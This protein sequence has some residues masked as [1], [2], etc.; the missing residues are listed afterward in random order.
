MALCE[1]MRIAMNL[2]PAAGY[3][4]FILRTELPLCTILQGNETANSLNKINVARICV[5]LT[6]FNA[7]FNEDHKNNLFIFNI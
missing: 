2:S 1:L 7:A 6:Y 5:L 3:H 4:N